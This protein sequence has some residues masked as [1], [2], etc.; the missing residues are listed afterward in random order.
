MRRQRGGPGPCRWIPLLSRVEKVFRCECDERWLCRCNSAHFWAAI[1]DRRDGEHKYTGADWTGQSTTA[2]QTGEQIHAAA[3]TNKQL[4]GRATVG[5]QVS[6][7]SQDQV[8]PGVRQLISHFSRRRRIRSTGLPIKPSGEDDDDEDA[9]C[10]KSPVPT[11]SRLDNETTTSFYYL[12]SHSTNSKKW[13]KLQC[14]PTTELCWCVKPKTGIYDNNFRAV[15]KNGQLRCRYG[16][17]HHFL[18]GVIVD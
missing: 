16:I 18:F 14:D 12:V 7:L 1:D 8:S 13:N 2:Q 15:E 11:C 6:Q 10:S 5:G 17:S 3:E 9:P 4:Q